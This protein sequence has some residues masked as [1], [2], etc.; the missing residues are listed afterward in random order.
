METGA[1]SDATPDLNP[2]HNSRTQSTRPNPWAE[3]F[4]LIAAVIRRSGG[5]VVAEQLAPYL[6]VP[7]PPDPTAYAV[8]GASPLTVNVDES[9]VLPALTRLNGRPEVTPNGDIVYVFPDL[10]TSASG[11]ACVRASGRK[12][13]RAREAAVSLL[14]SALLF[15]GNHLFP[16]C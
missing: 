10:M 15:S 9:F 8:G 4:R 13:G 14:C 1:L 2:D 16:P 11:G 12:E 7:A 5:A 6:D 3:R